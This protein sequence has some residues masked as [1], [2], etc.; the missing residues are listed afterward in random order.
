MDTNP[1][2]VQWVY[3]TLHKKNKKNCE[4]FI[5]NYLERYRTLKVSYNKRVGGVNRPGQ[6][7]INFI[8][9]CHDLLVSNPIPYHY[10]PDMKICQQLPNPGPTKV[11]SL[12]LEHIVEN[13]ENYRRRDA[14]AID[15]LLFSW[16]EQAGISGIMIIPLNKQCKDI[17][18]KYEIESSRADIGE[19]D[20][21]LTY[22]S[23]IGRVKHGGMDISNTRVSSLLNQIHNVRPRDARVDARV[24]AGVDDDDD[25]AP[26]F[27]TPYTPTGV[28][29]FLV[30]PFPATPTGVN[31][32]LV[33][34]AGAGAGVVPEE[35]DGG[36]K[37]HA[38][39]N[40]RS[41]RTKRHRHTRRRRHRR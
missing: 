19:G 6:Y 21:N 4:L 28:N 26:Y 22:C 30:T 32:F 5:Q 39:T 13:A 38:K 17:F 40:K 23:L 14:K 31:P 18:E 24:D 8:N 20:G 37:R 10:R 36:K 2:V 9:T 35:V 34:P 15:T 12:L 3:Q 27:A 16:F 41:T 7:F 29:P 1:S 33:T 25:G 11:Y